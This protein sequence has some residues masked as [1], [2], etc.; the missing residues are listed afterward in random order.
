MRD[1]IDRVLSTY[2]Y[3]ISQKNN[4]Q[5]LST[6]EKTMSIYEFF[7]SG[8]NPYLINGQTQLIAGKTCSINDP[9]IKS[10]ELLDTAK[11]NINNN[12]I[13]TGTTEKFCESILLLRKILN[14]KS[15]YYSIANRTK[16][17]PDYSKVGTEI[18]NFIKEHNQLDID[19]YNFV[20]RSIDKKIIESGSDFVKDLKRF[21][22]INSI[23]NP[24]FGLS[25]AKRFF[26]SN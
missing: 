22:R 19:L 26:F 14:W 17:K 24:I 2:Y 10:N 20:N 3:V 23:I 6:D 18:R 16:N 9:L 4:T 8:I 13:L 25:R 5:N 15:P 1:P 12:F 7:N 21:K 11:K